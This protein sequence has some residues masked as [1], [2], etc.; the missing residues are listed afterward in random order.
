VKQCENENGQIVSAN[1]AKERT[2]KISER[3][4]N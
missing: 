2:I 3:L 4:A 1:A